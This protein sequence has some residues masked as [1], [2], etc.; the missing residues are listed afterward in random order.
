MKR[1]ESLLL[2]I[3]TPRKCTLRLTL[4]DAENFFIGGSKVRTITIDAG[5][6]CRLT[7]KKEEFL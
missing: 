6:R 7:R 2:E 3:F 1:G 5:K 4:P